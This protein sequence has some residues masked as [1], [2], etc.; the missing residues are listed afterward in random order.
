VNKDYQ[1]YELSRHYDSTAMLVRYICYGRVIVYVCWSVT[2]WNSVRNAK[3]MI[4]QTIQYNSFLMPKI[5][6]KFEWI[7]R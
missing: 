3:H 4:G 7:Y 6:Q 2:S 5:L 1:Y